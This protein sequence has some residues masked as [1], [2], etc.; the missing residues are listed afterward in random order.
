MIE[1]V[2]NG[3]KF[4]GWTSANISRSLSNIA[5]GFSL[6]LVGHDVEGSLIRLFPGDSVEVFADGVKVIDGYIDKLTTAFNA[7]GK[8]VGVQ[9]FEKTCDL[10]DCC[11]E[12]PVEWRKKKIDIII[13]DILQKFDLSFYNAQNVDLGAALSSFAVDPGT[14]A[15]D[16]IAKLCKER[17]VLP[18]SNGLGKVFLLKPSACERGPALKQG[19]NLLSASADYSLSGRFSS[20]YVYG[21]GKAKKR[22]KS[23]KEDSDVERF[24]PLIIV[25]PNASEKE[26]TDARA[27]WECSIRKAKSMQF[28]CS[29]SGWKI[30]E[31]KVWE[32]GLICSFEAP[33]LFVDS[34]LDLLVSSVN[35]SFGPGGSVVNL[36]LCQQDSFE[37]QPEVKKQKKTSFKAPRA[38]VWASISKA[39]HG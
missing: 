25:D 33:E 22:V 19:Q 27:E 29:V 18:V 12:S 1:V 28:K 14:K 3:R 10:A 16:A 24:R 11:V 30:S 38:N 31:T 26:S 34:P 35:Y 20:Y 7:N 6:Q 8:Q 9:G 15:L 2:A 17:G 36:T 37:P 5:A 21:T 4:T 39:V 13:S 32:P 23:C